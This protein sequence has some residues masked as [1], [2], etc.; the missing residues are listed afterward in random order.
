MK[1]ILKRRGEVKYFFLSTRVGIGADIPYSIHGRWPI[2]LR[3]NYPFPF[4]RTVQKNDKFQFASFDFLFF[5]M[6]F[7]SWLKLP[8]KRRLWLSFECTVSDK[9]NHVYFYRFPTIFLR[10]SKT[11]LSV[12]LN[13]RYPPSRYKISRTESWRKDAI[14][15]KT[16]WKRECCQIFTIS[17]HCMSEPF[18]AHCRKSLLGVSMIT[19][20][21]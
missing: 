3:W 8:L 13:L 18:K 16:Q 5:S 7:E 1:F 4:S 15:L 19:F 17:D 10:Q 11:F 9:I 12:Q 6:V 14:S 20:A 21:N 2:H